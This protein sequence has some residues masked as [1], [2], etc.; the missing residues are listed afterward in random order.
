MQI[1]YLIDIEFDEA[2]FKQQRLLDSQYSTTICE[3]ILKHLPLKRYLEQDLKCKV[4]GDFPIK[5]CILKSCFFL[6]LF[7][8]KSYKYSTQKQPHPF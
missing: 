7:V 5:Q 3:K 6:I 4:K 1:Q 2:V 8:I